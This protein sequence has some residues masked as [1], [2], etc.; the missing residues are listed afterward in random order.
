VPSIRETVL[1]MVQLVLPEHANTRGSLYGG[2]M[3]NWI[4]TAATMAAMRIAR[5]SVVLGSMDDLDFLHAVGIGDVVT[6]RAQVEH[7]GSSSL[8]IGVEVYSENPQTG[9]RHHTT[10]SHL[11]MV[12]VDDAGRPRPIAA[13]VTPEGPPEEGLVA[14]ARARKAERERALADR[15][16]QAGRVADDTGGATHAVE[17]VRLVFPEDAVLGTMMFAGRLMMHLDEAASLLAVRYCRGPVV[18]ASIDALA[19]YAPIRIGEIVIYQAALNHVGHASME[20]GV[21]VLAEHPLTGARRHTCT[22]FLTMV[23]VDAAGP[24]PVPPYAPRTDAERRRWNEA[25]VRRAR[26]A[27]RRERRRAAQA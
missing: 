9:T 23:H 24:T 12:A 19:F 13:S 4:T 14:A 8:E 7:V 16:E 2:M 21:R 27:V 20:V 11:A 10:A 15:R 5:G 17:T 26:R 22:A 3:M 1:E 6:L 18:T 25:E